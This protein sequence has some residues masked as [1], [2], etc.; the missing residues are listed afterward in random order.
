MATDI[1][2]R[3][4]REREWVHAALVFAMVLA[5]YAATAPRSVIMEDDGLFILSSYFLGVEHPPGYPL[6]TLIGHLF[7]FLPLGSVAYRV[8]LV[9]GVF[10][11]LTCAALW[12]CA[13][14]LGQGRLAAYVAALALAVSPVY[15]S[16][17]LIADVYSFNTFFFLSLLLIAL[18]A[19][20]AAHGAPVPMAEQ[21]RLLAWFA[22][23]FGLSLSNHWPLMLLVAPGFAVL[24]WPLR[25]EMLKRSWLLVPL[26]IIG[27]VPY[28]WMVYRSRMDPVISFAG[29]LDSWAEIWHFLSRQGYVEVDHQV[30]S[31]WLDRVKFFRFM[32]GQLFY[33]FAIVGTLLAAAGFAVQWQRLG[34]R[35]S[36]SLTVAFLGP[37]ALLL[38]LLD[39]EYNRTTAHIFHVYPLPAYVVAALWLGLGFA[40]LVERQALRRA[41][42]AAAGAVV[43]AIIGAVGAHENLLANYGWVLEYAEAVLT[44]LPKQAVLVGAGEADLAPVAYLHM[45]EHRRPD[46]SLYQSQ[47]L[48]LGDRLFHPLRTA[49]ELRMPAFEGMIARQNGTVALSLFALENIGDHAQ[50]DRW[51]YVELDKSSHDP[52]QI[53]ID[54]P[55]RFERFFE[56]SLANVDTSN[57]WIANVQNELRRRYAGLLG[58]SLQRGQALTARQLH[59]IGLLEQDYYGALGLAEGLVSNRSGYSVGAVARLLDR[60]GQLMPSDA[61]KPHQ[62]EFFHLRGILRANMKDEAGAMGDFETALSV[63]PAPANPAIAPMKDLYRERGD[64]SGLQALEERVAH[65]KRTSFIP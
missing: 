46:I 34:R 51:L 4:W 43:L 29:P 60:A 15:W 40:W 64:A 59:H 53:S 20:P 10:G 18:R 24:L 9:S 14:A 52:K 35:V 26:F 19:C 55:E 13:R 21:R 33:Q 27:L 3:R 11:A 42:A 1:A 5:L 48:I 32:G 8:H 45:V 58:R 63:W 7:T 37:T 62:A 28:V 25:Y 30:S 65:F 61:A 17:S 47:G 41:A 22:F 12:L 39:F 6:F 38:S 31:N 44:T 23:I 56:Q 49:L 50:R 57:A 16:Q 36:A 2:S 54:I